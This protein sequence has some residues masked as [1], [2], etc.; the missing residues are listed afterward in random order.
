MRISVKSF[1]HQF[2]EHS[3]RIRTSTKNPGVQS[4]HIHNQWCTQKVT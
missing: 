1:L 4:K 3:A 2:I